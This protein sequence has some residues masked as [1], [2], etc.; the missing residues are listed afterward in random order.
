M[1]RS[2]HCLPGWNINWNAIATTEKSLKLIKR[3]PGY[4]V[5]QWCIGKML[6]KKIIIG[7]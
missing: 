3:Q 5:I 1:M 6:V 7:I 2:A 4:G